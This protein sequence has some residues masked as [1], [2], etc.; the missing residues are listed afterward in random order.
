MKWQRVS[1]FAPP[2]SSTSIRILHGIVSA[3]STNFVRTHNTR[4]VSFH[5]NYP[6]PLVRLQNEHWNPLLK[7]ARDDFDIE[8]V[9]SDSVLFSAQPEATKKK[10][11]KVLQ[12]LDMWQMAGCVLFTVIF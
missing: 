10:L 9:T 12:S 11:D 5:Q 3:H 4:S 8:L 7:W 2:C 1:M 6:D